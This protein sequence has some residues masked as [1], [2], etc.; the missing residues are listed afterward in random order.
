[1]AASSPATS[2][3]LNQD[4]LSEACLD[5]I[6]QYFWTRSIELLEPLLS[7]DLETHQGTGTLLN[8]SC[9][10]EALSKADQSLFILCAKPQENPNFGTC[11]PL[12]PGESELGNSAETFLLRF[13]SLQDPLWLYIYSTSSS[14]DGGALQIELDKQSLWKNQQTEGKPSTLPTKNGL[15]LWGK[16]PDTVPGLEELTDFI[17]INLSNLLFQASVTFPK[18]FPVLTLQLPLDTNECKIGTSTLKQAAV[19]FSSPLYFSPNN[20]QI[21]LI[22]ALDLK[23]VGEI[24]ININ[25]PLDSDL[26]T[27]TGTYSKPGIP[28]IDASDPALTNLSKEGAKL[29]LELEFSKREKTLEKVRFSIDLD[30]WNLIPNILTLKEL[31][32][33]FSVFDPLGSKMVIA[34]IA[35]QASLGSKSQ[36]TLL[37]AGYY[38]TNQ[39]YLSLDSKIPLKIADLVADLGAQSHGIPNLEIDD[40]R[41]EYNL[42]SQEFL[43]RV[44]V[45]GKWNIIEGVELNHLRFKIYRRV[46]CSCE[47]LAEFT[48]AGVTLTLEAD[49]DNDGGW[50]FEGSTG[51]GQAI[52]IGSLIKDL[53]HKFGEVSL[54]ASLE[55]LTLQNLRISFNTKTKDFTFICESKLP[56]DDKELDIIVNIDLKH[57]ESES[58][59]NSFRGHIT[60]SD[61][62][63]DLIFDKAINSKTFVATYSEEGSNRLNLARLF[64]PVFSDAT[65]LHLL[66]DIE[67]DLKDALFAYSKTT[68]ETITTTKVLFG[69]DIGTNINLSNLPLVGKR[70]PPEQTVSVDDLQLLIA[71]QDF[72]PEEIA[73]FNE[74]TPPGV[75]KIP[76]KPKADNGSSTENPKES[77]LPKGLN[78]AAKMQFG[79]TATS[80]A[81]PVSAAPLS[82]APQPV[83]SNQLT[84]S[85]STPAASTSTLDNVTWFELKRSFGPV[86]FE[87]VG[88]Q[89]KD[90]V[91]SFFVDVALSAAGLTLSFEGLSIGSPLS[92]F[93][94]KYN[95]QGLGIDYESGSDLEIGGAFLKLGD[96]FV[97]TAVIRGEA[98]TLSAMGAY[99]ELQGSPSLFIYAY[100]NYPLGG[101]AFFFV[102]GLA[103]GFGYNRHITIPAIAEVRNFPLV[104]DAIAAAPPDSRLGGSLQDA[105]TAL[106]EKLTKLQKYVQPRVGEH[107]LAVGVKFNS[108][109]QID[110]FALLIIPFGQNFELDVLGISTM[111]VPSPEEGKMVT[112]VAQIQMVLKARFAPSEG[113]L[114]VQAQLTEQS[115]VF[116][117]DCHLQGGFAF[118]SWFSGKHAGDFVITLGGYHPS[119]RVPAH[120]PQV[121]RLTFNWQKTP[122]LSMKGDAYFALTSN[123]MMAGGHF[124]ALWDGGDLRAWY[125]LGIDFLISWKPFHYEASAYIDIGA[126]YTFSF[127]GRHTIS[128]HVGAD[129]EIWGPEFAGT[130]HVDLSIISFD[131]SF[132]DRTT[133]PPTLDWEGFQ[134]SFLP[135]SDKICSI[136]VGGGLIG[137][138]QQNKA[139][140][141]IINP[142]EFCLVT[143]TLIPVI[144][145]SP[146]SKVGIAPMGL[147]ND[148]F[149]SSTLIFEVKRD[150]SVIVTDEFQMVAVQKQFPSALWGNNQDTHDTLNSE[151]LLA[152]G[153]YEIRPKNPPKAGSSSPIARKD[154]DYNVTPRDLRAEPKPSNAPAPTN[155][156]GDKDFYS[157]LQDLA[158]DQT[159]PKRNDLLQALGFELIQSTDF[160]NVRN[161]PPLSRTQ[162]S[163]GS[164][165]A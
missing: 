55:G 156:V 49:Y 48:I 159:Y 27:A 136:S 138:S 107:F 31:S 14:I 93:E 121:P 158:K 76:E 4:I 78:V 22:G 65:V 108:F 52:P 134:G 44:D 72:A 111:T 69:L 38:P 43:A 79:S 62:K 24:D 5:D 120:Y 139:E 133:T 163:A 68:T 30:N 140:H 53:G 135:A 165:Q 127:F 92:K 150:K 128:V 7:T 25:F 109:K 155:L 26:I 100:L 102:E 143:N 29:E 75:T 32:F 114:S 3:I 9:Q 20:S 96:D 144:K 95:I 51:Y 123:V 21:N 152:V 60:F 137:T 147:T 148:K 46:T 15:Y 104:E 80:L 58:F 11:F 19:E 125:R 1:M 82:A 130:A 40:L 70:L 23:D 85:S 116:S 89:Y 16:L 94:P 132:G 149:K 153:G 164:I 117:P 129:V 39:F 18:G 162:R 34:S 2:I 131:I 101:P 84:S 50:Q 113:V 83:S 99:K 86:H 161:A 6:Q 124:E 141:W 10:I 118:F 88:V 157:E 126:S 110:S 59:T 8:V 106:G 41:A 145:E 42:N 122:E 98:F 146:N 142:K 67:I 103:A 91:I 87:R 105:N 61:L 63:F 33:T 57:K 160:T 119:F 74:L 71:S 45:A 35:A 112:P 154:L 66:E 151:A 17:G 12:M 115:Y 73:A 90:A 37:C 28:F 64:E 13:I 97:G 81:L 36:I 54:P 47:I 77:S 56:I